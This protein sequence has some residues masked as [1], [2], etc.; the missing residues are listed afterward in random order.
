MQR[1]TLIWS[2]ALAGLAVF[3]GSAC[4]D[5]DYETY[6][7]DLNGNGEF[8]AV[9]SPA[10]GRAVLLVNKDGTR[11]D[12]TVTVNSPLTSDIIASHIHKGLPGA[13]GGV[14]HNLWVPGIT[15][16]EPFG[17]GQ[18]IGRTLT[19][20]TDPANDTSVGRGTYFNA[21]HLADLRAGNYY[22]NIHSNNFKGGEI[23]GQLIRQQ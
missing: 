1:R 11:W 7:A 5:H 13:T 8:P 22:V 14:I 19:F 17:V 6:V 16:T 4:S 23:R 10:T 2:F 21:T 3:G 12:I 15:V 18:P 9:N 20:S